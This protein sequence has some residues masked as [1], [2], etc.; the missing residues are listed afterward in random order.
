MLQKPNLLP[1]AYQPKPQVNWA[2]IMVLSLIMT[3]FVAIFA[4]GS[5][6]YTRIKTL[7][8][9]KNGLE[10]EIIILSAK[11]EVSDRMKEEQ[12]DE[13]KLQG[14]ASEL[15][16]QDPV[17]S[18]ILADLTRVMP[19]GLFFT[20]VSLMNGELKIEG[21][22]PKASIVSVYVQ[23]LRKFKWVDSAEID[24]VDSLKQ[25]STESC[26]FELT[27]LLTV[28]GGTINAPKAIR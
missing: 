7:E 15:N 22:A 20:R 23:E 1:P 16:Q 12:S 4:E 27:A 21:T 10:Q 14:I 13:A 19:A 8:I 11:K 5:Q 3:I 24:L 2:R 9:E 26:T 25:R 17:L 18:N 28:K 6:Y